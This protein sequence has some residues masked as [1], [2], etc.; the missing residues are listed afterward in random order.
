VALRDES[1]EVLAAWAPALH[2]A[3][4]G[5]G[6]G[7]FVAVDG[8]L[9]RTDRV[10]AVE[11]Y[12]SQKHRQHSMNVQVIAAQ[13]GTPLWFSRATPGR[14]H[15]LSAVAPTASSKP[16]SHGRSSS[17]PTA[18]TRA[19][20]PPS[21]PPYKNHREQPEHYQ[22]FNRDHAPT[23]GPR[24]ARLR[25]TEVLAA[26]ATSPMLHPPHRYHRSGCSR[27]FDLR[28]FKMKDVHWDRKYLQQIEEV[29][30]SCRSGRSPQCPPGF[31][32]A[33][34]VWPCAPRKSPGAD[35][36]RK[37]IARTVPHQLKARPATARRLREEPSSTPTSHRKVRCS[38]AGSCRRCT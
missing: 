13:D 18:P 6:E 37:G 38:T 12:Y 34:G 31:H 1:L 11:P 32:P 9:I 3:L 28:L 21:A 33:P 15:D 35:H 17:S 7:D 25:A 10:R 20:A 24:R 2:E 27:A 5:L 4:V 23:T 16:A 22:Q 36:L 19:P 14:T 30:A 29:M 8:T 26:A